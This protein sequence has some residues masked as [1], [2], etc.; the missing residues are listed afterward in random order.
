MNKDG[1]PHLQFIVIFQRKELKH[2]LKKIK[3]LVVI[4]MFSLENIHNLLLKMFKMLL[5]NLSVLV[6][7]QQICYYLMPV[8]LL[9]I[10]IM[11]ILYAQMDKT[12]EDVQMV[13]FYLQL[14]LHTKHIH[15]LFF[16][17]MIYLLLQVMVLTLIL[18]LI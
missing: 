5:V 12:M 1:P 16:R 14:M 7:I 3:L 18:V 11:V 9:T 8:Q 17:I 10:K 2:G 13:K 4:M 15:Y 6:F